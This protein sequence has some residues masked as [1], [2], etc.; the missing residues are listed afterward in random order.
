MLEVITADTMYICYSKKEIQVEDA[1]IGLTA[2]TLSSD[3]E[4]EFLVNEKLL[5]G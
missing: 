3:G 1:L 5:K 4:Y 2:R